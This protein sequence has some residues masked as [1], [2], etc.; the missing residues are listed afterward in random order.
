M[1]LVRIRTHFMQIM[2]MVISEKEEKHIHIGQEHACI[3][4][5]NPN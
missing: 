4:A 1:N 2:K 5:K 3:F